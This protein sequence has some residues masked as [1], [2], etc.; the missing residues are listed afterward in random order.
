MRENKEDILSKKNREFSTY[1]PCCI[2]LQVTIQIIKIIVVANI[3]RATSRE[4]MFQI[5]Q[6]TTATE[7]APKIPKII[8]TGLFMD[9]LKKNKVPLCY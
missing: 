9:I 2:S 7:I 5:A 3:F 8:F 6:I 1:S 4:M